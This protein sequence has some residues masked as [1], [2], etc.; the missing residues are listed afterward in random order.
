MFRIRPGTE[1]DLP[2]AL[3][4]IV[5]LAV[6]EREPDAV[7]TTVESMREDGF[8][9]DPVFG[10][11][12]AEVNNE[13]VG[14]SLF[15]DRY[16]TWR[17]KCLYLEDLIVNQKHRGGGIG[18]AL[19]EQTLKKAREDGYRGMSWQVLDWNEP[20]IDFYNMYNAKI[21]DGWLNCSF[22]TAQVQS[23]KPVS[24]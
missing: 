7:V 12:V 3:R 24:K 11:F 15:Y 10:F 13:V 20:A 2:D 18:K 14:I 5:E 23:V 16:S 17:G 9:A 21:E 1:A 19:F 4:L 8:G 22:S 6:F